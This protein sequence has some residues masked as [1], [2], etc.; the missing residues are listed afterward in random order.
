MITNRNRTLHI[1]VLSPLSPETNK[2]PVKKTT[3]STLDHTS[4]HFSEQKKQ[5]TNNYRPEPSHFS[6]YFPIQHYETD[7]VRLSVGSPKNNTEFYRKIETFSVVQCSYG[8]WVIGAE[9]LQADTA[10][11]F[12]RFIGKSRRRRRWSP[13]G[14]RIIGRRGSERG[15]FEGWG[16]EAMWIERC[17]ES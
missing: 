7:P 3:I 15:H 17:R 13:D 5:T 6:I 14:Y 12:I 11:V 10:G 16:S 4:F 2:T 8:G 9:G 1:T